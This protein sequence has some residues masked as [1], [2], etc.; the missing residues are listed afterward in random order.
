M[1]S[2]SRAPS[3]RGQCS[4]RR[5]DRRPPVVAGPADAQATGRDE[6]SRADGPLAEA[7]AHSVHGPGGVAPGVAGGRLFFSNVLR[8]RLAADLKGVPLP[9]NLGASVSPALLQHLP[10]TILHGVRAAYATSF[11]TVFL[12]AVPIGAVAF[13]LT[14]LL[15]ELRLRSGSD[16]TH[17]ADA[18]GGDAAGGDAARGGIHRR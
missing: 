7:G 10:A 15:P 4:L 6:R 13:V 9:K 2:K 1:G 11:D 5:I 16:G 8:G 14:W 17:G 12:V 18:A 3:R